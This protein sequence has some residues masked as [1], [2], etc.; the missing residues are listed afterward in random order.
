MQNIWEIDLLHIILT[1]IFAILC[2]KS[3]ALH[4]E[5]ALQAKFDYHDQASTYVTT[6]L[7]VPDTRI[8]SYNKSKS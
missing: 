1:N 8:M 6:D 5:F 4:S 3:E 2:Q 7:T